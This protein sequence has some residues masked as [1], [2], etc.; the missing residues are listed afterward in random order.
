MAPC[1]CVTPLLRYVTPLHGVKGS[2]HSPCRGGLALFTC[3]LERPLDVRVRL[4]QVATC[5]VIL[6]L[7]VTGFHLALEVGL[8]TLEVAFAA[9]EVEFAIPEVGCASPE[10]GFSSLDLDLP[11]G[12]G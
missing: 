1:W 9:P 8:A 5:I 12:M 11:T 4:L 6:L 10:A 3:G 7:F 2:R